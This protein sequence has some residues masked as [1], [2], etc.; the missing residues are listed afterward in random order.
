MW[1]QTLTSSHPVSLLANKFTD[2]IA[3]IRR[4]W[5]PHPIPSCMTDLR[6]HSLFHSFP[7]I[8]ESTSFYIFREHVLWLF[9]SFFCIWFFS[10]LS[11]SFPS[12]FHNLQKNLKPLWLT[13]CLHLPY[14]YTQVL[15]LLYPIRVLGRFLYF[16]FWHHPVP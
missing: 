12:T 10:P 1:P 5:P 9:F 8:L 16:C 14:I 11:R 2:E 3:A 13:S 15:L 6:P 7:S 4:G